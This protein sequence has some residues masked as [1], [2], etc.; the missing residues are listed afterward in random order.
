MTVFSRS[1]V[2]S[3][4][5]DHDARQQDHGYLRCERCHYTR[6]PCDVFD[7]CRDWLELEELATE[8]PM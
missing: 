7:L 5:K 8:G 4:M 1:E 3:M 6:H 2:E